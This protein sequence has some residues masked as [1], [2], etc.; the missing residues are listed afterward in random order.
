MTFPITNIALII[1]ALSSG[2]LAGVYFAF[3]TFIMLARCR[4][5]RMPRRIFT[6]A[7]LSG[8]C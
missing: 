2:L 1:A 6:A 4:L 5:Q 7:A 3:S 8:A